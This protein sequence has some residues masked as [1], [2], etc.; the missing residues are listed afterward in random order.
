MEDQLDERAAIHLGCE[1][2]DADALDMDWSYRDVTVEGELPPGVTP[3]RVRD[4]IDN[5]SDDTDCLT[6]AS[7]D[8]GIDMDVD[9]DPGVYDVN[10]ASLVA[11]P[12]VAA[13]PAEP[14]PEPEPTAVPTAT[15][16]PEPTAAPAPTA[17]SVPEPTATAIP[18]PTAV[19]IAVALDTAGGYDG[20][21]ITL[22]G[23]VASD[24]Q[25]QALV[26]AATAS[27]GDGNVVDELEIDESRAADGNDALVDDLGTVVGLFGDELLNGTAQLSDGALT[28]NVQARDQA[29]AD[30]LS[31]PGTGTLDVAAPRAPSFTG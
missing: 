26:D 2:I 7:E 17:T 12:L 29:I 6:R 22:S 18:D 21:I 27:V 31:L 25:R 9:A 30:G 28:W 5:G 10:V 20:R 11:A 13:V 19:P 16:V 4:V 8:A 14:E 24:A 15:A 1:G 23:V 3:E